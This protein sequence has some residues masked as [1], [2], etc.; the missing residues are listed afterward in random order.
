MLLVVQCP[1]WFKNKYAI[2]LNK[3][4]PSRSMSR[5]VFIFRSVLEHVCKVLAPKASPQATKKYMYVRI[6]MHVNICMCLHEKTLHLMHHFYISIL[7]CQLGAS[8]ELVESYQSLSEALSSLF[9]LRLVS[10]KYL[11]KRSIEKSQKNPRQVSF[12]L[13]TR[14]GFFWGFFGT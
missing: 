6:L 1:Q 4:R 10:L 7:F 3:K 5:K 8:S 11:S 2:F 13:T 9:L 12:I 14:L